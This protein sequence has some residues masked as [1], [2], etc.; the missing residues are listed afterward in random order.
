MNKKAICIL[1]GMIFAFILLSGCASKP[2]DNEEKPQQTNLVVDVMA[3]YGAKGNGTDSDR[4]IIQKAIDDV[5]R[6]GGGKVVLTAG[7]TFLSGNLLMRS[8]VTLYIDDGACLLQNPDVNDYIEVRGY[9]YGN[10]FVEIGDP[11]IP[12]TKDILLENTGF[13]SKIWPTIQ[14]FREVWH[15]NYPFIYADQGTENICVTGGKD[16]TMRMAEHGDSCEGFIHMNMFG[17]YRVNQFE[18]SNLTVYYSGSHFMDYICCNNGLIYNISGLTK[19]AIGI[20]ECRMNDGLHLDRCQNILVE[21][22]TFASGDDSLKLGNSYGDVRRD[23]WASSTDMQ[24]MQNIEISNCYTPGLCSGFAFMSLGGTAPDLSQV[25]MRDIY[26][27]DCHFAGV[28]VWG[29]NTVWNPDRS[30]WNGIS[31]PITNLRWENNDCYYAPEG[32]VQQIQG[33]LNVEPIS[34]CISDDPTMH[35]M[36]SVYN[37]DFSIGLSYWNTV[38]TEGSIATVQNYSKSS[39]GYI[40]DLHKGVTKLYEGL[41][42]EKGTYQATFKVKNSHD[43]NVYLFASDQKDGILARKDINS[44]TWE[45]TE[46]IVHV[47]EAGNYRIGIASD[48]GCGVGSWAMIDDF[49]LVLS[50]GK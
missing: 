30:M 22:C 31:I 37:G 24:P 19:R 50:K 42:L 38:V 39:Y 1:F 47:S 48:S 32:Y 16:S 2:T 28:K 34:D 36:T 9:D 15:W 7:R 13:Y 45:K 3:D 21:N 49:K 8:N 25:Q 12:Y 29:Q 35:S 5:S 27:H 17:F 20:S 14:E 46:L 41:Y 23:R 33:I 4:A 6:Q 43:A 26:I 18:V 10:G 44:T 40:G 11:Y